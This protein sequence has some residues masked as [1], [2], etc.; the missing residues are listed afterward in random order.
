M[1]RSGIFW[2][3]VGDL[4]LSLCLG[5]GVL[6]VLLF[7]F[8]VEVSLDCFNSRCVLLEWDADSG[9]LFV[10]WWFFP[11]VGVFF[12]FCAEASL[13]SLHESV[14]FLLWR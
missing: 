5:L 6:T 1:E 2:F 8:I 9:V 13:L 7:G 11:F 12:L 3:G 10:A 4:R 14:S